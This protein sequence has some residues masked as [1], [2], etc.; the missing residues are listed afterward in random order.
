MKRA[1][2]I[3]CAALALVA[4]EREKREFVKPLTEPNP[5]A[6]SGTLVDLQ[7]GQ[8]G[9]GMQATRSAG[10]YNES[11]A[12]EVQQGKQWY[13]WYNC[14]GCH[15]QG[16]GSIGPALMDDQWIYGS[17]PDEIFET[18]MEGRPNGMPA[19]KGRIPEGQAWQLVAY[20]R[21]MSGLVSGEAAP[22][23]AEGLMGAPPEGRRKPQRPEVKSK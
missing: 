7:P 5:L 23:R 16:G 2:A 21:S 22:N 13:R 6:S 12:Y 8:P 18:I 14:N 20:V 15:A 4:C 3:A 11:S 9:P 19:F 1:V 10:G 17:K